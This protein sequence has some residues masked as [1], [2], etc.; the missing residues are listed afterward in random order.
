MEEIKYSG[1]VRVLNKTFYEFR[2][3]ISGEEFKVILRYSQLR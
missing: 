1:V 3:K 2:I